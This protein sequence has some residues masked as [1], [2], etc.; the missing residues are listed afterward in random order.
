MLLTFNVAPIG[1]FR[2]GA[3]CVVQQPPAL[4]IILKPVTFMLDVPLVIAKV[5][6]VTL[7]WMG[8]KGKPCDTTQRALEMGPPAVTQLDVLVL[9][10][11]T[12]TVPAAPHV[13][14]SP[15]IK[16]LKQFRLCAKTFEGNTATS[17][18]RERWMRNCLS[19]CF[20]MG[21]KKYLAVSLVT[22]VT[23]KG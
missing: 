1:T 16:G 14:I 23:L 22:Q 10:G 21:F 11:R 4:V 20:F 13:M 8:L 7:N 5:A 2:K 17:V 15:N 3:V 9:S 19:F 18:A 6:P 12:V